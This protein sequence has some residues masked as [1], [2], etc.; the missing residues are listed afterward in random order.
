MALSRFGRLSTHPAATR[1][2]LVAGLERRRQHPRRRRDVSYH[3]GETT[4]VLL[5]FIA[6]WAIIIGAL[7]IWG[8]IALRKVLQHEWLLILNGGLS[9][10]F[11][12]VLFAQPGHRRAGIRLDDRLVRDLRLPLH[13]ACVQ[14]EAVPADLT[15]RMAYSTEQHL[16]RN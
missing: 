2:A 5:L 4:L 12:V 6:V 15:N 16:L 10:A 8:A 9:I 3:T 7:Q 14:A 11:G 13:R 1:S